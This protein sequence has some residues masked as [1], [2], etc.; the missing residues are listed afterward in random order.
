M[1]DRNHNPYCLPCIYYGKSTKT[2]DFILMEDRRRPC[3][4]GDGCTERRTKKEV[5]RK[6]ALKATWDTALGMQM[7]LEGKKDK[8]IAEHF[9]IARNTVATCRRKYWEKHQNP[10]EKKSEEPQEDPA[11]PV[12]PPAEVPKKVSMSTPDGV[13]SI[14]EEATKTKSGIEAICT[15]DAILCLWNWDSADDLRRARAAINHLIKRL[16]G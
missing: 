4:G 3:P 12:T 11:Q 6:L 15:A 1:E 16:E 5:G 14:L 9:G 13:Y 8:E 2:C 7:W 10:S